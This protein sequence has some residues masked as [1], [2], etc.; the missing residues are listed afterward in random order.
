MPDPH[1]V[2]AAV[3]G[4]RLY[5]LDYAR[6]QIWH[7]PGAMFAELTPYFAVDVP[8]WEIK[9]H[10]GAQDVT[11]GVDMADAG[12]GELLVL[13][14]AGCLRSF[15]GGRPG[16]VV[17]I[18]AAEDLKHGALRS[19]S[20]A[21]LEVKPGSPLAYVADSDNARVLAVSRRSGKVVR[22]FIVAPPEGERPRVNAVGFANGKMLLIAGNHLV[23][24]PRQGDLDDGGIGLGGIEDTDCPPEMA[25][26]AAAAGLHD[27]RVMKFR[28]PLKDILPDNVGVYPGARRVYR[29]GIHEGVDF[30]DRYDPRVGRDIKYGTLVRAAGPGRVLRIDHDFVEMTPQ[31]HRRLLD[32]CVRDYETSRAN[33]DRFR[34]RQV[35]LE[36]EGGVVTVYAHLSE[37]SRH[38]Q[39]GDIVAISQEIGNVGNSGTSNGVQGNRDYP[40]LHFEIWMNRFDQPDGEYFGR[41]LSPW[42]TRRLWEQLFPNAVQRPSAASPS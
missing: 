9:R 5:L 28:L 25:T 22:Q 15:Q 2:A 10:S 4:Q 16:S 1:Y 36:H 12:Q 6:N 3:Q 14:E 42:E 31:E 23:A 13:D 32:Q 40:H 19:A 27:P 11:I 8:S 29:H 20:W 41:W 17:R 7:K 18:G 21:D 38:L 35:W 30:F 33:E 34:G 39:K 24:Y 37:V 26:I